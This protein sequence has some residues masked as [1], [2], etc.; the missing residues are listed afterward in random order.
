MKQYALLERIRSNEAT[1]RASQRPFKNFKLVDQWQ[2]QY[3]EFV[4][5]YRFL[6]LDGPSQTGKTRYATSL[7]PV[8]RTWYCDCSQGVVMLKGFDAA[9]YSNILLDE[10]RPCAAMSLK[11][12]LQASSELVTLGA[13]PTM[14]ASYQVHL[15]RVAIVVCCN[16][17]KTELD[18]LP[19]A[20]RDWLV[21]NSVYLYV[22]EPMWVGDD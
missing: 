15:H 19:A 21:A 8:G 3:R 22:G 13:S 20:D 10:L 1:L 18:R 11:K 17:W 7:C 5:R 16:L 4:P 14:V 9:E 12:A 2:E 6:V